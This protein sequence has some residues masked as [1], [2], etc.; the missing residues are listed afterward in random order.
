[1]TTPCNELKAN[2]TIAPLTLE[3]LSGA[4]I[5]IGRLGQVINYAQEPDVGGYLAVAASDERSHEGEVVPISDTVPS[6]LADGLHPLRRRLRFARKTALVNRQ[7]VRLQMQSW[8][9]FVCASHL[10]DITEIQL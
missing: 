3:S 8:H 5:L 1:M 4:T 10:I 2:S 6:H 7:V 9:G